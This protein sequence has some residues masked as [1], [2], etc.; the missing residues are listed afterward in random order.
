MRAVQSLYTECET[1]VKVE[2]KHSE[3]FTETLEWL[4][5]DHVYEAGLYSHAM[6]L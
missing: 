1:R 3:W 6:T 5:V 2:E 4:K